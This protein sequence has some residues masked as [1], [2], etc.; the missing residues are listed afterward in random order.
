[1]TATDFLRVIPLLLELE[2][3]YVNDPSDPGGE[4]KYGISRRAYPSLD[5]ANLTKDQASQ[6]YY[7]DYWLKGQCQAIPFPLNCYHFDTGVN[8]GIT[9]AAHILQRTVGVTVDG[10]I[11]PATLAAAC[12]MPSAQYYL[13][14]VERLKVYRSLQEWAK[15]GLGWTTRLLH[16]SCAL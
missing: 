1:M 6:I 3:G 9:Q 7:T 16:L 11:G 10:V 8:Q 2:G 13:Y 14:L 15:Y 4:T 5:I 12:A